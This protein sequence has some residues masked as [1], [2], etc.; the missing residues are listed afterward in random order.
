MGTV[1]FYTAHCLLLHTRTHAQIHLFTFHPYWFSHTVSCGGAFVM[2]TFWYA[3][4]IVDIVPFSILPAIVTSFALLH[5][6]ETFDF[7]HAARFRSSSKRR[8]SDAPHVV[9]FKMI[10]RHAIWMRW[11]IDQ[12]TR[13]IADN[14]APIAGAASMAG[15]WSTHILK[16]HIAMRILCGAYTVSWSCDVWGKWNTIAANTK[17][18][19]PWDAVERL[20]KVLIECVQRVCR[21]YG[22]EKR[23]LPSIRE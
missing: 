23:K 14:Q 15:I 20:K 6:A 2:A 13:K 4:D 8:R 3:A 17:A 9:Q 21:C 7:V 1:V 19:D 11:R 18:V 22:W 12:A 10:N 16:K 5:I